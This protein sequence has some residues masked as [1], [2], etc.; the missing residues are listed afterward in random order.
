TDLTQQ[1]HARGAERLHHDCVGVRAH[2]ALG[3]SL[4]RGGTDVQRFVGNYRH[5]G[6]LRD[7]GDSGLHE[8]LRASVVTERE[9]NLLESLVL[10][11]RDHGHGVRGVR[12]NET[13]EV[14]KFDAVK[15]GLTRHTERHRAIGPKDRY[16]RRGLVRRASDDEGQVG[17]RRVHLTHG[18]YGVGGV[19]TSVNGL[20]V[21]L[22]VQDATNFV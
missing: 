12:W 22:A 5:A 18:R 10:R 8:R 2:D 16:D 6:H 13:E 11:D 19:T 21:D 17:G 14:R 15:L 9:G 1:R 3:L 20:A 7:G 4:E